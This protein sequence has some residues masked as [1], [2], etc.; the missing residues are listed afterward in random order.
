[1][2]YFLFSLLLFTLHSFSAFGYDDSQLSL[3]FTLNSEATHFLELEEW[4]DRNSVATVTEQ[5]KY[6]DVLI[7]GC[8]GTPECY[9]IH[10]K[11][12]R[13]YVYDPRLKKDW[14]STLK[15]GGSLENLRAM[16]CKANS[17]RTADCIVWWTD[18]S[19]K[20]LIAS[21][22]AVARSLG[23]FERSPASVDLIHHNRSRK[24]TRL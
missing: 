23:L 3:T 7:V 20:E 9:F 6:V 8:A 1:M 24:R 16:K 17:D 10:E 13:T 19:L 4:A 12:G 14:N 2:R 15:E 22:P 18:R 11:S 5:D 21:S